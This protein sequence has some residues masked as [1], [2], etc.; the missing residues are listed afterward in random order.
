[1]RFQL[2]TLID[3][4]QTKARKGDEPLLQKQQQNYLTA[5][6]TIS[7]RANPEIKNSPTIIE[8]T[9][10][11]LGFGSAYTG[12]QKI[13][14]LNFEFE[15]SASH[16]VDTLKTDFDLV[17]IIKNLNETIDLADAAF[18]TKSEEFTN[19]VFLTANDF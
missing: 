16:T 14:K 4:T 5:V 12:K 7:L 11:G 9:V 1:M 2:L 19:T 6:Q 17:P 8:Q 15:F 18:I 10:K 3:I 13:W